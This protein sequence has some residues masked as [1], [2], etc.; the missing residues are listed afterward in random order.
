MGKEEEMVLATTTR[1][2][3]SYFRGIVVHAD[4]KPVSSLLVDVEMLS[5]DTPLTPQ[6]R[7]DG[8]RESWR[9]LL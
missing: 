2:R 9:K 5:G 3:D 4:K 7:L 6:W 8:Y 1:K